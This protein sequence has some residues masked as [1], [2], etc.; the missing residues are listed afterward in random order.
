MK[1]FQMPDLFGDAP[2]EVRRNAL[3]GIGRKARA[4]FEEEYPKLLKWFETYD[5]LYVLSFCAFYFLTSEAGIDKEAID[6]KLDFGQHH[7][8]LL[9]AL[10]LMR[11][12]KGTPQP[13]GAEAE[14]LQ[15]SLRDLTQSLLFA[16]FDFPAEMSGAELTKRWV[17]AEMRAQTSCIRNWAYPEQTVRHL[18]SM[19][20]GPL[21]GIIASQYQGITIGQMI[22]ALASLAERVNERLNNHIRKLRPVATAKDFETTYHAYRQAFPDVLDDREGMIEAFDRLCGRDLRRLQSVLLMHSDLRL[23]HIFTFSLD[24]IAHASGSA[25]HRHGLAHLMQKWS[26]KFGDL[27]DWDPKH[28]IYTNP[29]LQRP[30][31]RLG[32]DS[33]YW[34]QCG[35]YSHALPGMLELLIP[36]VH[37]D[38]YMATRSRYLEDQVEAQCRKAFPSGSV[39][40]GSQYRL[41]DSGQETYENDILVVIDSTAI[42]IE[43][44]ANLIDPPARRGAEYRLIDTLENLVVSASD[45]AQ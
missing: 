4:A 13:L 3:K 44:K 9:Q 26:Y 12:R 19:F 23:E 42:I 33:F 7:L 14:A 2:I 25:E 24:D 15:K 36:E 29:I 8:E 39:F 18:K 16:Q 20:E 31:I 11:S 34:V 38:E 32:Q 28:F 21:S 40:R 1:F 45:Q 43:C 5:P 41:Q 6:G 27:A 37:R 30:F 10:A 22:D 17:L 35:I